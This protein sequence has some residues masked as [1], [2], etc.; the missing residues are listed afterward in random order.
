MSWLSLNKLAPRILIKRATV[1]Y[2]N[3]SITN[4]V[5][6][7]AE[8]AVWAAW[9]EVVTG[10]DGSGTDLLDVGRTGS[11]ASYINN[12]N[13][14]APYLLSSGVG[15]IDTPD[16]LPAGAYVTFQYFDSNSDATQG[17]AYIYVHYTIH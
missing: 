11:G 10:F 6:I 2:S 17:L 9:V 12:L 15:G 1:L 14:S 3:T 16:R 5:W 4:I 13:I 8:G 7:P